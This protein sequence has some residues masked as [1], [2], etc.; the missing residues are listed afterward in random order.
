MLNRSPR[1]KERQRLFP[2][3]LSILLSLLPFLSME[4]VIRQVSQMGIPTSRRGGEMLERTGNATVERFALSS[5]QASINGLT[6]ECVPER[7]V[8]R[9]FLHHQL[10]CNRLAERPH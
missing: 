8:I 7:E 1:G 4:A 5:K 2:S 6:G 3:Q 10:R 9:R